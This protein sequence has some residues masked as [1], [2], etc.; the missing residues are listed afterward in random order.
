MSFPGRWIYYLLKA[1]DLII[2]PAFVVVKAADAF[3]EQ[4][5]APNQLWQTDFR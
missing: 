5:S 2:S 3:A 4:T 1:R